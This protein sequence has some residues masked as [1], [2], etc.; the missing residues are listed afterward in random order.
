MYSRLHAC[1]KS[2]RWR[3]G[4]Y[5]P[6]SSHTTHTYGALPVPIQAH[7]QRRTPTAYACMQWA[8]VNYTVAAA[9]LHSQACTAKRLIQIARAKRTSAMLSQAAQIHTH[10]ASHVAMTTTLSRAPIHPR[11]RAW[12]CT[13][14]SMPKSSNTHYHRQHQTP[15]YAGPINVLLCEPQL[16]HI[17]SVVQ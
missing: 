16:F 15:P 14:T 1:I 5:E 10:T 2:R 6:N 17:V 9:N 13:N 12:T 11:G 8:R 7:K 3:F 4:R